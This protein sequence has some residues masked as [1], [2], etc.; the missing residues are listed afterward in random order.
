MVRSWKIFR[1]VFVLFIVV[2]GL[3]AVAD[4]A[5]AGQQR[6]QS[7]IPGRVTKVKEGDWILIRTGDSLLKETA[8]KISDIRPEVKQG[9]EGWFDP[10]YMVEY[11]IEKLDGETGQPID[12]PMNVVRA[13]EHETEEN[14]EMLR[15]MK[16]KPQRRKIKIDGKNVD[17]VV[18]A[19][20]EDGGV[21]VENLF[22]DQIGI[23]GRV[24][25]IVRMPDG[26]ETYTAL[27]TVAFGNGR[28]PALQKY[29]QKKQAPAAPAAAP[30]K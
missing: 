9:E 21:L 30:A 3:F 24:G 29:L 6:A 18:I 4:A 12:K 11:T 5:F 1:F 10:I 26:K 19:Q 17:V 16:G 2:C 22:S 7:P 14:A 27:E 8:T 25:V 23:D 15:S 20:E 28:P 13:L